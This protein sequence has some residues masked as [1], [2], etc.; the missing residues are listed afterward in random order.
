MQR[1]CYTAVLIDYHVTVMDALQVLQK[2]RDWEDSATAQKLRRGGSGRTVT[3]TA[4]AAAAVAAATG[5]GARPGLGSSSSGNNSSSASSSSPALS[6]Q[7]ICVMFSDNIHLVELNAAINS[8]A[9]AV[10]TDP[11]IPTAKDIVMMLEDER[12]TRPPGASPLG[13]TAGTS[14]NSFS[15]AAAVP[16][17]E[18]RT[19]GC[20]LLIEDELSILK[21][22]KRMFELHGFEVHTATNGEEGLQKMKKRPYDAVFTDIVMPVMDGYETVRQFRQWEGSPAGKERKT[23]Q[24]VYAVSAN[25]SEQDHT[26]AHMVGMDGFASKPV[27]VKELVELVRR[28]T[29]Q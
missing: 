22:E 27:K 6:R 4:A 18:R 5:G 21:F 8:G 23:K 17:A 13:G 14:N 12:K 19:D 2:F 11:I 16:A 29:F 7:F 28:R 25:A 10:W 20:V 1:S 15:A 26:M 3:A 9:D 24:V